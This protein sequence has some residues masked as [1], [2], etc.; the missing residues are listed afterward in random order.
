MRW[1]AQKIY[2]DKMKKTENNSMDQ[3]AALKKFKFAASVFKQKEYDHAVKN[4]KN[5]IALGLPEKL[6]ID[7][8][9]QIALAYIEISKEAFSN[10]KKVF[11]AFKDRLINSQFNKQRI[12]FLELSA[13]NKENFDESTLNQA[14]VRTICNNLARDLHSI[15]KKI[16][17]GGSYAQ[18]NINFN[19]IF[20]SFFKSFYEKHKGDDYF[21]RCIRIL[22]MS[23][24]SRGGLQYTSPEKLNQIEQFKYEIKRLLKSSADDSESNVKKRANDELIFIRYQNSLVNK[25]FGNDVQIDEI[26][27]DVVGQSTVQNTF[28]FELENKQTQEN[29]EIKKGL[30]FDQAL[31]YFTIGLQNSNEGEYESAI[32]NLEKLLRLNKSIIEKIEKELELDKTLMEI[33]NATLASS[34]VN[35]APKIKM[36]DYIKG[37]ELYEKCLLLTKIKYDFAFACHGISSFCNYKGNEDSE[38]IILEKLF[39]IL[40]SKIEEGSNELKTNDFNSLI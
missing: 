6:E 28:S 3:N 12:P 33:V 20:D 38:F 14:T 13:H 10:F 18:D 29:S 40:S 15:S 21:I 25:L 5:A 30:N 4:F 16:K 39:L 2:N 17:I 19:S 11:E 26:L 8:K 23:S 37:I 35:S 22:S 24:N 27:K 36:G 32:E 31:Q 1:G 9:N 34:Y 7:A